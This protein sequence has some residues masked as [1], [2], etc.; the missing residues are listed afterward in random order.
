[1]ARM[2]K[3]TLFD[4]RPNRMVRFVRSPVGDV[5]AD[6]PRLG[7]AVASAAEVRPAGLVGREVC[8]SE[9]SGC[10]GAKA[11]AAQEAADA[12]DRGTL[13]AQPRTRQGGRPRV[14]AHAEGTGGAREPR[15]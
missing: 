4:A 9:D 14:N 1:M 12:G 6:R 7:A 10:I 13:L 8:A 3:F 2:Q 15:P 11:P 5:D